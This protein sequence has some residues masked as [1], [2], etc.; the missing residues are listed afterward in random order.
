M[1][2]GNK[3]DGNKGNSQG[4]TPEV[5]VSASP[6]TL[7]VSV[8][9]EFG[10]KAEASLKLTG[11]IPSTSL[12]RLVDS[13]SRV[14]NSV[15]DLWSP[16]SEAR[17]LRA[18]LIRLQRTDVALEIAKRARTITELEAKPVG[19]LPLKTLVP[20]LEH[21]S[22]EEPDDSYMIDRWA[23]LLATAATDGNV[24]PRLVSILSELN[25]RQAILCTGISTHSIGFGPIQVSLKAERAARAG[26]DRPYQSSFPEADVKQLVDDVGPGMWSIEKVFHDDAHTKPT[27]TKLSYAGSERSLDLRILES[28]GLIRFQTLET[29]VYNRIAL[30]IVYAGITYLGS[31]LLNVVKADDTGST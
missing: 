23:A 14:V 31:E 10:A 29:N 3:G 1:N 5:E 19:D 2:E 8:K 21:G 7:P 25:G 20:L 30:R 27:W 26:G 11:E 18:D 4:G 17:G 6:Q 13:L 9:A 28:L 15:T 24:S 22:M 12:G 16:T